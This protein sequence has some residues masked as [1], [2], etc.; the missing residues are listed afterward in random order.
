DPRDPDVLYAASYQR[1]RRVWTLIAGGPESAIYKSYDGGESW[2]KL[3]RGLPEGAVGRIGLAVSPIDPD[4]VYATVAAAGDESGFFRSANRGESWVRQSDTICVDP[5][6]YQEIFPDP[7]HFDRVYAMDVFLHVTDDGGRTFHRPPPEFKHVDHH[8]LVFDPEDPEYLL[9]GTDGGLYESWDRGT[10]WKYVANLPV[11]QFYRVGID[12]DFPFY[13]VYGGTQDNDTQ[14]GPS[15]TANVHGIRNS[16]WF[17]TVGG[18]GYQTRVDPEDPNILY[19]MWQYGGLVRYDKRSG[20]LIDI[21]PQPGRGEEP[22]K[23]NWDSPLLISPHSRT[24]LYFGANRLFRSDD[25]GDTW[26]PV[27]PDLSRGIDRNQ[28]KVMGRVWSMDAVWKNVFT[29]SYGNMVALDESP[30]VEGLIYAGMD[31]GLIQV[32]EDGGGNWRE[33]ASFPG[34]PER[35]YVADLTASLHDDDTVFAVFNN[36]K[37]GDFQPYVLRSGDRGRSWT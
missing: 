31:D 17:I 23:W 5:Q 11:T 4:V 28:L 20:E 7:H 36:H 24:R 3:T 25:R 19:S 34:V 22:L 10:T 37:S 26:E 14:G 13:N 30:R 33:I 12:N 15:R 35:T 9:I 18:D 6:Y 8:A 2:K 32:T 1:R 29:S 27:S 21:Q 16:D